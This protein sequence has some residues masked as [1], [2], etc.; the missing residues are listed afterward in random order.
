MI[1]SGASAYPA[2]LDI[3]D[4]SIKL[5]QLKK[6]GNKIKIKAMGRTELPAGLI[7]GGVIKNQ[8]EVAKAIVSLMS[9]P[10]VGKIDTNE[11]VVSLPEAKTFLKLIEVEKTGG[12]FQESVLEEIE[13][14]VPMEKNDMYYDWQL[15][16]DLSKKQL[17][18]VG[19]SPKK[20][21][22]DYASTLELAKLTVAAMEPEPISICRCLLAEENPKFRGEN[23]DNYGVIDVGASN[24][25]LTVY[26]QG[27]VVFTAS[28]PISGEKIT[29]KISQALKIKREQAE[30]AKIIYSLDDDEKERPDVNRILTGMVDDLAEKLKE[31]ISFYNKNYAHWGEIDKILLCGGGANFKNLEKILSIETDIETTRGDA[32]IN[33]DEDR[34]KFLS[35]FQ[36]TYSL[37]TK[38]T[39]R[40][41]KRGKKKIMKVS[42][43]LSPTFATTI[44]LALRN[45]FVKEI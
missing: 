20:L 27:T 40:D 10:E 2:G 22:D 13:K 35:Y 3:S 23:R 36:K 41:V 43:D 29:E 15:I 8:E 31:A 11:V 28:M 25:S 42:Q 21:I 37:E 30:R 26:S 39:T 18:L 14:N 16:K 9:N 19:A 4:L 6:S 33:M 38:L 32:L 5:I 17:I 45:I 34:E 12:D 7:E 24:A 1:L 44:G